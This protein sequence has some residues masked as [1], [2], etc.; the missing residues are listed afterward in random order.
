[1]KKISVIFLL[2]L[3]VSVPFIAKASFDNSLYYGLQGNTQVKELQDFLIDQGYLIGN[4]TGNFF[5][6]TLSAVKK[7]QTANSLL[8]TGYFGVLSRQKANDILA[9]N[10]QSS[11][12]QATT[13]TGSMSSAATPPV[14]K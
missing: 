13:E 12:Q 5:S 10:L 14:T 6:L 8:S 3:L 1:M 2:S 7:F 9:T 11:N 4:S